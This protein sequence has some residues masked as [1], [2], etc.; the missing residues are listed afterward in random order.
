MILNAEQLTAISIWWAE[1]RKQVCPNL[2]AVQEILELKNGALARDDYELDGHFAHP[3]DIANFD[4]DY[5]EEELG[6]FRYEEICNGQKPTDDELGIWMEKKNAS[7]FEED[8]WW[9][10]FY[11]WLVNLPDARLYFRSL[12]GDGGKLDR[13]D[14][15]FSSEREALADA[16]NV[17]ISS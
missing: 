4:P 6:Q 17:E 10:H 7:V 1:S 5:I 14:G 13:F 11:I 3:P 9:Y 16:G 12:H 2:C 15:P 8:G